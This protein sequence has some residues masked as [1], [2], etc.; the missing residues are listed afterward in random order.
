ML[1][2][3]IKKQPILQIIPFTLFEI[4]THEKAEKN[5]TKKIKINENNNMRI[6]LPTQFGYHNVMN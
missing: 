2:K 3:T 4:Q 6:Y 5:Q 1:E